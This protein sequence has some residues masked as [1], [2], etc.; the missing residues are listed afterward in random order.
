MESKYLSEV[1]PFKTVLI[2]EQLILILNG[3]NNCLFLEYKD[4]QGFL[5]VN[6]L[7]SY[8]FWLPKV[9]SFDGEL[10]THYLYLVNPEMLTYCHYTLF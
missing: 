9:G 1:F 7:K 3:E 4:L 6:Y 8:K 2:L 5:Q 10:Q